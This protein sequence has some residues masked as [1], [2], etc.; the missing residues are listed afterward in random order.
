MDLGGQQEG[1]ASLAGCS[2]LGREGSSSGIGSRA[3]GAQSMNCS[4]LCT[5]DARESQQ[6]DTVLVIDGTSPVDSGRKHPWCG[7]DIGLPACVPAGGRS[8][9][10]WREESVCNRPLPHLPR[11]QGITEIVGI[12]R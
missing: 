1:L 2:E 5:W 10:A 12:Q 7:Q 4:E 11:V 9:E 3:R 8:S 6:S